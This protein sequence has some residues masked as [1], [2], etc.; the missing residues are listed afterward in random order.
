MWHVVF[1]SV[2]LNSALAII[3]GGCSAVLTS[4]PLPPRPL[5]V[6]GADL[7]IVALMQRHDHAPVMWTST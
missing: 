3:L 5:Y 6:I 7:G 4:T 1:A 2:C